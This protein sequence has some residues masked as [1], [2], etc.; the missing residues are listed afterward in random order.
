MIRRD[1]PC[2]PTE[3]NEWPMRPVPETVGDAHFAA[4]GRVLTGHSMHDDETGDADT[5]RLWFALIDFGRETLA[6]LWATARDLDPG[7]EDLRGDPFDLFGPAANTG[8]FAGMIYGRD[9][10]GFEIVGAFSSVSLFGQSSGL[11]EA[12]RILK[13]EATPPG[14]ALTLARL[15]NPETPSEGEGVTVENAEGFG[16][17]SLCFVLAHDSGRTVFVQSDHAYPGHAVDFGFILRGPLGCECHRNTDGSTDCPECGKEAGAFI[18]EAAAYLE[19]V[20]DAGYRVID[21]GYF[22]EGAD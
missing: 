4:L 2:L 9:S 15:R 20:T 13:G 21:P 17:V 8:A 1:F 6:D 11:A 22:A 12:W 19:E 14:L 3:P 18:E 5:G 7:E 10:D 16:G